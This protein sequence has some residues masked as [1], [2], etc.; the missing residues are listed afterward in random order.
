MISCWNFSLNVRGFLYS[1]VPLLLVPLVHARKAEPRIAITHVNV[2]PMTDDVVLRDQTV[3]TRG[4]QIVTIGP[5]D[6]VPVRRGTLKIDGRSRY[7]LPGLIDAH[8]HLYAPEQLQLYVANGVTT[9]F[10]LNGRPLHL[11]WRDE[12]AKG[13]RLGPRIYTV[14]PKFDRADP[15]DK[16]VEL[17]DQYWRQGY[18][19]IKIYNQVS[20][21]EYPALIT[22]AK[23]HDMLIVGHIARGPGFEMTVNAGQAIAH[24]EEYLYTFFEEH[25][26]NGAPDPESIPQAVAL[27]KQSGA[28]VIATLVTYEHI[29]EQATDLDAFLKQ[30]EARYFAPWELA[31]IKEPTQNPYLNFDKDGVA[32]LKRNYPFQRILVKALHDAGVPILTGT[33]SGSGITVPGFSLHEELEILA[34]SGLTPFQA[35]ECATVAPARF[36]RAQEFGTIDQ[37]KVA[38]LILLRANPLDDVANTRQVAG[39]LVQGKWLDELQLDR[40]KQQVPSRYARDEEVAKEQFARDP[41]EAVAFLKQIDPFFELGSA[42]VMDAALRDGIARFE[43]LI[44]RITESDPD[45]PLG[46][47]DLL[48]DI[49][50]YLLAKNRKD[51]AI[52]LYRFN[53]T[54]HPHAAIAYDRFARA[55]YKLGERDL[56][57]K[58]YREALTVDPN[59]WNAGTAKRRIAELSK[60]LN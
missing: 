25:A 42:V 56:S 7:L 31:D 26:K 44:H 54:E 16:A 46:A 49:A 15:P 1:I 37:G 40:M 17:V 22:E 60:K 10:N 9:V 33:D 53:V 55:Y 50:D 57:L 30:P 59:Y 6:K 28:P 48:N 45:S 58:Y 39:V 14:G 35:L 13:Q 19:G 32:E 27:T 21:A 2:I 38:D 52:E 4:R 8:V 36:L 47:P 18:D 11:V 29:L 51:D 24:A 12:T 5:A 20:K 3:L 34:Q 23:K 41:Q 43:P